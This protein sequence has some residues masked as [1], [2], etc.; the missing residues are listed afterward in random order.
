VVIAD[1]HLDHCSA[2]W[3]CATFAQVEVEVVVVHD[4]DIAGPRGLTPAAATAPAPAAG[5]GA[6]A[7]AGSALRVDSRTGAAREPIC[8]AASFYPLRE[9]LLRAR[10]L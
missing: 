10:R 8:V 5:I 1:G 7:S 6:K 2:R 3:A 4:Q 9:G